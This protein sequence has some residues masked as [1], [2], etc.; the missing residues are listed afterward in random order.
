MCL[1]MKKT[2]R[3][4]PARV[5]TNIVPETPKDLRP[6]FLSVQN[7]NLLSAVS[8]FAS[9]YAR[10]TLRLN[11]LKVMKYAG[12]NRVENEMSTKCQGKCGKKFAV[13][14]KYLYCVID[15][16]IDLDDPL[17]RWN[18]FLFVCRDCT[19]NYLRVDGD[20]YQVIQ[21]YPQ[22]KL[23]DITRLCEFGFLTKYIF[24]IK[25]N[26]KIV[27][28]QKEVQGFHDFYNAVK[29]IIS[30]KKTYEQITKIELR[31][32]GRTLFIETDNDCTMKCSFD[33]PTKLTTE[34]EFYPTESKMLN[35]VNTYNDQIDLSYF[36]VVT[37]CAYDTRADY[38]LFFTIK[39]EL[40]C[41]LCTETKLYKNVHPILYCTK[42]GFTDA[43][44]FRNSKI[45]AG[46]KYFKSCIKEKIKGAK[47]IKYYDL[48]EYKSHVDQLKN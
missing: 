37:V 47:C 19:F 39:C 9:D 40:C 43:L 12:N 26:Y 2:A 31:T 35:F 44:F 17:T 29:T 46:L 13:T 3:Y 4:V 22:I 38:D 36:Y 34:L 15:T 8:R 41:D 30:N 48:N 42:C 18:K 11:N 32:Y 5:N 20:R 28:Y 25:L 45:T 10:G 7:H 24:P 16:T 14:C 21:L 33:E 1:Q 27:K 23:A 6:R